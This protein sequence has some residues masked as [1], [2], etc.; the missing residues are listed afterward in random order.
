MPYTSHPAHCALC[1]IIPCALLPTLFCA[2][3]Q[4][5][6]PCNL[7][8]SP[9]S[10]HFPPRILYP[11]LY[12]LLSAP[13]LQHTTLPSFSKYSVPYSLWPTPSALRPARYALRATPCALRPARYTHYALHLTP[14]PICHTPYKML[15]A[16]RG[17]HPAPGTLHHTPYA[18]HPAL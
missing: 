6:T 4:H 17:L 13:Y 15:T 1:F 10:L 8:P 3:T 12:A 2:C 16:S 5:L 14:Y 7:H 18:R 11:M 9:Y